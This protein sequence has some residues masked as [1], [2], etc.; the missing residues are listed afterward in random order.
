MIEKRLLQRP[1]DRVATGLVKRFD[2]IG[3]AG[4]VKRAFDR[5]SS[6]LAKR[7]DRIGGAGLVK[8]KSVTK[9]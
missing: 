1:F 4:L 8:V 5:V 6:G 7:F 3:G 2:R 9:N